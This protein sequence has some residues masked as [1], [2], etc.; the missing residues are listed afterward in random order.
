[1]NSVAF[2]GTHNDFDALVIYTHRDGKE[3]KAHKDAENRSKNIYRVAL[4]ENTP[5]D[6]NWFLVKNDC[7]TLNCEPRQTS[8]VAYDD[9]KYVIEPLNAKEY[10][11]EQRALPDP[12]KYTSDSWLVKLG[13][14]FSPKH[15][16]SGV[17]EHSK[18]QYDT[19][20]MTYAAYW[21]PSDLRMNSGN[22]YSMNNA[23][24]LYRNN[25]LDGVAT[26]FFTEEG[27][28]SSYG[29]RWAKARFID[30]WHTRHRI[31]A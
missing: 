11:G 12:L 16:I 19:R 18:Q 10:T 13:Y 6:S 1:M 3:T 20:D 28:K 5:Q 2:A 24:G 25:V 8:R 17:Y 30:E 26:D 31:G 21:Q 14:A 9:Q 23:R 29:L 15:Y 22:W 27:V 7:P 4:A